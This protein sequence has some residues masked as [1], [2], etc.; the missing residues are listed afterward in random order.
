MTGYR[1]FSYEFVKGFPIL[2]KGFEIET[3]MTIHAVD[4]N[5]KI[6]EIPVEYRDR[7][8]GSV[9]KLNT[10]KD[11][12][13]VL[14]TIA[15]LFEEYR[16]ALFFN[17][18]ATL[19]SIISIFVG[20]FCLIWNLIKYNRFLFINDKTITICKGRINNPKVINILKVE[21]IVPEDLNNKLT[22]KYENKNIKLLHTSFS[23]LGM[24]CYIGPLVFI[25][26]VKNMNVALHSSV[27]L[28][29]VL[30]T[31]FKVTPKAPSKVTDIIVN[32]LAWMF[33]LFVSALGCIGLLLTPFYPF[34]NS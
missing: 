9:S 5:Y 30:P 2:S 13:K 23:L 14:K 1:A 28:Y 8:A 25:P 17:I 29:E 33:V 3:E 21:N 27:Q 24:I 12:F 31:L 34:L 19:L 16:P 18:F 26:F 20:L 32:I 10:F 4:K 7:P 15:R 11:G 22:V 6:V